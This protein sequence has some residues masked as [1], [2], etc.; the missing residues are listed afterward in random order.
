MKCKEL[1]SLDYV[2]QCSRARQAAEKQ[3]VQLDEVVAPDKCRGSTWAPFVIRSGGPSRVLPSL[4]E[5]QRSL[6]RQGDKC[7]V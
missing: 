5:A 1:C 3:T 4:H 2:E 7:F 6:Q